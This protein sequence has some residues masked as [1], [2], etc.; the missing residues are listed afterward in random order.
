MAALPPPPLQP[1]TLLVALHG[2]SAGSSEL[3]ECQQIL[4]YSSFSERIPPIPRSAAELE[5][6]ANRLKAIADKLKGDDQVRCYQALLTVAVQTAGDRFL[7]AADIALTA[8]ETV[9][10]LED[11]LLFAEKELLYILHRRRTDVARTCQCLFRI[12]KAIPNSERSLSLART[13]CSAEY[14]GGRT[15]EFVRE[16]H[17][18]AE[19]LTADYREKAV[20]AAMPFDNQQ[21][22]DADVVVEAVPLG[23]RLRQTDPDELARLLA[24]TK[25]FDEMPGRADTEQAFILRDRCWNLLKVG[26]V[27]EA[28]AAMER[29]CELWPLGHTADKIHLCE[30]LTWALMDRN[31]RQALKCQETALAAAFAYHKSVVPAG[32]DA[33]QISSGFESEQAMS[34]C[35]SALL[36]RRLGNR[37][38]WKHHEA[39]M[40]QF[41]ALISNEAQSWSVHA[42]TNL[43]VLGADLT[44]TEKSS[45]EGPATQFRRAKEQFTVL[46][47]LRTSEQLTA[48]DARRYFH[49]LWSRMTDLAVG[50]SNAEFAL[51]FLQKSHSDDPFD[52]EQK[53][54]HLAHAH[55][56]DPST[57]VAALA[58]MH[59]LTV[60]KW[61]PVATAALRRWRGYLQIVQAERDDIPAAEIAY[62]RREHRLP[63]TL[64]LA[65]VYQQ[66]VTALVMTELPLDGP[67]AA[68][69]KPGSPETVDR[70]L[71]EED[72]RLEALA[73]ERKPYAATDQHVTPV[74]RASGD[75]QSEQQPSKKAAGQQQ[76]RQGLRE[77]FELV[78]QTWCFSCNATAATR[79]DKARMIWQAILQVRNDILACRDRLPWKFTDPRGESCPELPEKSD[80]GPLLNWLRDCMHRE[81][82]ADIRS[83]TPHITA[84]DLIC[85]RR[86]IVQYRLLMSL[87][88]ACTADES[89][90]GMSSCTNSSPDVSTS[91]PQ[92]V[93]VAQDDT[94][95]DTVDPYILL[96]NAELV[97]RLRDAESKIKR[98]EKGLRGVFST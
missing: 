22:S 44:H 95:T 7:F 75:D 58:Q 43:V 45:D 82:G 29:A 67:A 91:P 65:P 30:Q 63:A 19:T 32:V 64:V 25:P 83:K 92:P 50:A 90:P 70:K 66:A 21:A 73:A 4:L 5:D 79:R 48:A 16:V 98:H 97:K 20:L 2:G 72:H 81:F 14:R 69:I 31:P 23:S 33:S 40:K 34:S 46:E 47:R 84:G 10:R 80:E 51:N 42:L 41:L 35:F 68:V 85:M 11:K 26:Q 93:E 62:L 87:P 15:S 13:L 74:K 28:L 24:N 36:H 56:V 8:Y 77:K 49:F 1:D 88:V 57:R 96:S 52:A 37:D 59:R 89:P 78:F 60:S 12:L 9:S 76:Q 17:R 6:F 3:E 54:V 39:N 38:Q 53:Q 94:N 55:L 61:A 86:E 18:Y 71:Q 27:T